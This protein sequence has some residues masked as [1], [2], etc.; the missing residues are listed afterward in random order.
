MLRYEATVN[1]GGVKKA[2]LRQKEEDATCWRLLVQGTLWPTLLTASNA[3]GTKPAC[4]WTEGFLKY[5]NTIDIGS[6]SGE[7]RWT[8]SSVASAE[9]ML[10][11][12]KTGLLSDRPC[13]RAV[14]FWIAVLMAN[15]LMDHEVDEHDLWNIHV[16]SEDDELTCDGAATD[17]EAHADTR[18]DDPPLPQQLYVSK[19]PLWWRRQSGRKISKRQ[20]QAIHDIQKLG[21]QL[22]LPAMEVSE[23]GNSCR[24]EKIQW[25]RV[26]SNG[27]LKEVSCASPS[28]KEIWLE[29]GFGLGDN[30][31]CMASAIPKEETKMQNPYVRKRCF[32]GAEIHSGGIGTICTRMSSA[33]QNHRYWTDYTLWGPSIT[34]RPV[35]NELD[36]MYDNLR[37]YFGDGVKLLNFIPDRSV[38][39]VIV[40]FPDPF[41]GTNQSSYRLLQ[42]DV[43]RQIRRILVSPST[44]VSEGFAP[45][46]GRFYLATDHEGYHQWSCDQ[47]ERFNQIS[48]CHSVNQEENSRG[49]FEILEPTPDRSLW[50]PVI[51]KYELKGLDE[52][53]NTWLSCWQAR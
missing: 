15:A 6:R 36:Q 43:L 22:H 23:R 46:C 34:E 30:L 16:D 17:C 31:L 32:V 47:V 50:L 20:R 2:K 13:P 49:L 1:T 25:D 33:I 41:M 4:L 7:R 39:V 29:L 11:T 37:I 19:K 42:M 5:H 44:V 48:E 9:A 8:I 27:S 10:G 45:R 40:A 18:I 3:A 35:P 24:T 14:S 21:F 52:G 26:F 12:F 28:E 51:S 38:S 53:R